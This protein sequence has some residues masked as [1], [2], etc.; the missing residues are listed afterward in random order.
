MSL[1][2]LVQ[3]GRTPAL[4]LTVDV[5]GAGGLPGLSAQRWLRVLPEQR[6]V[7]VAEWCGQPVLAKLL[8]VNKAA[9]H[10][11]RERDGALL[12][13]EQGLHT[14]QLLADGLCD[15]EGGWLLFEYLQGS[16]S[17]WEAWRAVEHQPLLSADQQAVLAEALVS[18][19]QMHLKGLWQGG[20]PLSHA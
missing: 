20:P 3:A 13:A 7:G 8:V 4:P 14:P 5:A 17:L 16:E 11:Q 12:L 1:A 15:G 9:R 2:G 10:F 19:A 6:Y 18:I